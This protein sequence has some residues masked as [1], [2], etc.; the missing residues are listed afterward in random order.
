MTALQR[1]VT[2]FHVHLKYVSNDKLEISEI[3]H[4]AQAGNLEFRNLEKSVMT[5]NLLVST[6][7]HISLLNRS[8]LSVHM[9]KL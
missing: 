5:T 6:A 9:L 2:R 3:D 4:D 1:S 7:L 8:N